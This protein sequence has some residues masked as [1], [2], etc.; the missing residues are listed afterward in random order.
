MGPADNW[1]I[2]SLNIHL[3]P[4]FPCVGEINTVDGCKYVNSTGGYADLKNDAW[5]REIR[6][7]EIRQGCTEF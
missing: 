3:K 1:D 2:E 5:I 4:A 7:V 6:F